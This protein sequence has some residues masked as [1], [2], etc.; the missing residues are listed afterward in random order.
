M[1][2]KF[3]SNHKRD[4]KQWRATQMQVNIPQFQLV[5]G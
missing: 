2:V 5:I 4:Y 1:E 3:L